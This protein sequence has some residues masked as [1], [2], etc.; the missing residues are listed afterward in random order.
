M[1]NDLEIEIHKWSRLF[2]GFAV[3][4][5]MVYLVLGNVPD[6]LGSM[7]GIKADLLWPTIIFGIAAIGGAVAAFRLDLKHSK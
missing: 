3:V 1:H 7:N 2:A 5:G 4:L 6:P